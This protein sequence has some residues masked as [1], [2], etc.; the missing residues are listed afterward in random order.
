MGGAVL[1]A[2]CHSTCFARPFTRTFPEL[3]KVNLPEYR[4]EPPDILLIEAVRAIRSRPTRPLDVLFMA[5]ANAPPPNE[6]I[7]GLIGVETDGT[8]NLGATYGGSVFV[9][10]K[11]LP[12]IKAIIEKHLATTVKLV[13]PKIL[14]CPVSGARPH[15]RGAPDPWTGRS[16]SGPTGASA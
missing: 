16:R 11:T 14:Q 3:S 9:E 13:D 4:V 12:E 15:Q 8:I 1:S 2:G 10:G 7:T 5:L 6:Q